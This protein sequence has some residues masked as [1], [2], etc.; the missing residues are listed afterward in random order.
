M[1]EARDGDVGV[2]QPLGEV[3]L[4]KGCGFANLDHQVPVTTHSIFQAGSIGKQ[5]TSAAI[6]LLG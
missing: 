2:L 6:M 1:R 3:V 4:A 5:F